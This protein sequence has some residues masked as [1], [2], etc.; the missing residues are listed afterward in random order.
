[1]IER[2]YKSEVQKD[3]SSKLIQ[4][5]YIEALQATGLAVVGPPR[6]AP[7]MIDAQQPLRYDAAVEIKP[8]IADIDINGFEIKKNRYWVTDEEMSAQLALLQKNMAQLKPLDQARPVRES[9]HVL[10]DYEG[11]KDGQPFAETQKTENFTLQIGSGKILKDFD[12][13]LIGLMPGQT[14]EFDMTFPTDYFNAKLAGQ[15]IHFQVKLHEIREQLLPPLDDSLAK[16]MGPFETLEDLK[17]AVHDNLTNG[18]QKRVEHEINEQVFQAL[19]AKS[20]FEIPDVLI[21]EE[22]EQMVIDTAARLS[23]QNL[24][25]TKLGITGDSLR[26][27]YRPTAEAQVRRHL[28]LGKIIEQEKLVLSTVELEN[29]LAAMAAASGTTVENLKEFYKNNAD[30]LAFFKHTLLEKK[31]IDLIIVRANVE[32]VT[33]RL[34]PPVKKPGSKADEQVNR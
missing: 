33:P 4:D 31:A 6:I 15:S 8:E 11:F 30:R 20:S 13:Q 3:V 19:M 10:I 34:E 18:Y 25:P 32:E 28:L 16:Q 2:L 24:D 17:K 26:A 12:Q 22:L 23:A 27:R 9:D 14:R 29:G 7:P 5:S 21:D 1:M